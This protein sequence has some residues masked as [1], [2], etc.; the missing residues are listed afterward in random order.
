MQRAS[1]KRARKVGWDSRSCSIVGCKACAKINKLTSR[2]QASP[3]ELMA[4]VCMTEEILKEHFECRKSTVGLGCDCCR[5]SDARP[6]LR[7]GGA[8]IC[9]R[10]HRAATG[11]RIMTGMPKNTYWAK[12]EDYDSSEPGSEVWEEVEVEFTG[13][14]GEPCDEWGNA[15]PGDEEEEDSEEEE[16][17]EEEQ[18]QQPAVRPRRRSAAQPKSYVDASDESEESEVR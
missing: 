6:L 11:A 3:S 13:E 10:C 9:Y 2:P 7:T 1:V 5:G 14:D 18:Q 4:L 15:L 16:E 8:F 17:E 12:N